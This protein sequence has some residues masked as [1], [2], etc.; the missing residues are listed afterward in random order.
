MIKS[1]ARNT[2]FMA[3][4]GSYSTHAS[5]SGVN[6][7]GWDKLVEEKLTLEQEYEALCAAKTRLSQI[8]AEA[9]KTQKEGGSTLNLD[10][11]EDLKAKLQE[12]DEKIVAARGR[13]KLLP[14]KIDIGDYLI[15]AMKARVTKAEW[16]I[17]VKEAE[18]LM[19]AE[20]RKYEALHD[21]I[22]NP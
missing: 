15:D 6:L 9:R 11:Y 12:I 8:A 7:L 17:I 18:Q 1:T 16:R 19:A 22:P 10:E 14:N 5:R 4:R 21:P 2:H 13:L 3:R 20:L